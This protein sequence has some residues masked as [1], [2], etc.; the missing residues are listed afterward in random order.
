MFVHSIQ[1]IFGFSFFFFTFLSKNE[2]KC[3]VFGLLPSMKSLIDSAPPHS[4]SH[5]HST[6][7]S[8]QTD[9]LMMEEECQ[10]P[11]REGIMAVFIST[12]HPGKILVGCRNPAKA[13]ATLTLPPISP[14]WQLPQ[15]G[16]EPSDLP[17]SIA[18]RAT[19]IREMEEELGMS[20][21]DY[22]IIQVSSRHTRYDWHKTAWLKPEH[23]QRYRG[24]QHR[25]FLCQLNKE[26]DPLQI[27]LSRVKD[28]EFSELKWSSPEEVLAEV[29]EYKRNVYKE[30]FKMLDLHFQ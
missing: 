13:T 24:Q 14:A 22:Q 19:L 4:N 29:V 7:L 17:V 16:I 30:G 28:P 26:I 21:H 11:Y 9:Q 18:E 15:G 27:D 3:Q 10:L 8:S 12:N 6:S 25:W 1:L 5:S 2:T 20:E 23:A